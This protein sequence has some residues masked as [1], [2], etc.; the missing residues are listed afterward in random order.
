MAEEGY[1]LDEQKKNRKRDKQLI[2]GIGKTLL[3]KNQPTITHVDI[4]DGA[5]KEEWTQRRDDSM[6]K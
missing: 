2:L 3:T 4:E 5:R 1:Q 6:G